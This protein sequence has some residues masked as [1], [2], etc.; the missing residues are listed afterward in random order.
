MSLHIN[1]CKLNTLI[2]ILHQNRVSIFSFKFQFHETQNKLLQFLSLKVDLTI[3]FSLA[4]Q[5]S[6]F[7]PKEITKTNMHHTPIESN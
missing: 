5:P 2:S 3:S 1:F 7:T 4:L 6:N